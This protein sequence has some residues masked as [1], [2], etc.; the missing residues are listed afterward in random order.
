VA[1]I[2]RY[3]VEAE[4]GRGA[5]GVVYRAHDPRVSRPVALKTYILPDGLDEAEQEEYRQR[6][7]REAQAAGRL[8]H[9]GIVTIYDV[10]EAPGMGSPFIAMELVEGRSLKEILDEEVTLEPE[11]ALD[12]ALVLAEALHRAHEAGIVH[13]DIKPANILVREGD[14]APK[15]ADFGI[16]RLETSTLTRSGESLGSPAYMSPEQFRSEPVDGRSDLFSLAVI[17][18][19][20]LCGERPFAGEDMASLAYAVT[21]ETQVPVTRRAE[22]LHPGLDAFFDRALAKDPGERF[23][24][25]RSF[26]RALREARQEETEPLLLTRVES[27]P[28][29]A[30]APPA[31]PAAEVEAFSPE[32]PPIRASRGGWVALLRR[33][34]VLAGV[35]LTVLLMA[36]GLG[37][38]LFGGEETR[39]AAGGKST[40]YLMLNVRSKFEAGEFRLLLD[41]EPVYSRALAAPRVGPKI[42][43]KKP[44]RKFKYET[45]ES[46]IQVEPGRHRLTALVLPEGKKEGYERQAVLEI[47]PRDFLPVRVE[48][49]TDVEKKFSLKLD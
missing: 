42:L 34:P 12:M 8:S 32:T 9:P 37:S 33:R 26:I 48:I 4:I 17:L 13:R 29:P 20:A 39:G 15:I 46:R 19:Q 41:G 45:F 40:A 28:E 21:Q 30:P 22:A 25:G 5:M 38:G 2:G 3:V 36:L 49:G 10:E 31:P 6:F 16:A 43:G 23:P 47:D 27:A 24:D 35:A 44:I 11:Q 1:Q 14:G 18:Y 7:L